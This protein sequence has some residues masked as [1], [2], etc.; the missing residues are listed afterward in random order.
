VNIAITNPAGQPVAN[1]A[2]PGAPGINRI[3]WDLKPTKDLLTD[4]GGE[5]PDKFVRSG[6]YTVTLTYGKV[7]QTKKVQV[8]IAKG[9]ETR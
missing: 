7:K 5:G 1:L 6:E 8:E 3:N 4:Y 2:G 9:I